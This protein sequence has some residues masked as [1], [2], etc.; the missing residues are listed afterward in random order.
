VVL[1]GRGEEEARCVAALAA[2]MRIAF[3]TDYCGQTVSNRPT[4]GPLVPSG[5]MSK[6]AA[7]PQS[8]STVHKKTMA[9]CTGFW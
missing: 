2:S 1:V 4:S 5:H 3:V 8:T 7:V 6:S 9:G